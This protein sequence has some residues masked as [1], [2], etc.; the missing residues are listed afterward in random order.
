MS[1]TQLVYVRSVAATRTPARSH[2]YSSYYGHRRPSNRSSR[3]DLYHATF[4][5]QL[6]VI[7]RP[8]GLLVAISTI[9]RSTQNCLYLNITLSDGSVDAYPLPAPHCS[10]R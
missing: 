3:R 6:S 4:D 10:P 8:T 1:V 9:R 2:S 7:G 5:Y